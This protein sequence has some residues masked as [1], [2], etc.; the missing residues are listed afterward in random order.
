M[1]LSRILRQIETL[2]RV[3]KQTLLQEPFFLNCKSNIAFYWVD[4]IHISGRKLIFRGG[5]GGGSL[6]PVKRL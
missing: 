4:K 3:N 6:S 1:E 5:G 2:V